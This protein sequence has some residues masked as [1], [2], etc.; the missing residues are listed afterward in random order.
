M[1]VTVFGIVR[2]FKMNNFCLKIR[3]SQAQHAM[4]DLFFFPNT[5]VFYATF[6]I[7]FHRSSP[8]FLLETKR[9]ASIKNSSRF[10]ALCDLPD[11]FI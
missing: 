9:F 7:C 4:S 6:L 2:F 5:G 1:D 8:Q 11:A 10:S 3:V